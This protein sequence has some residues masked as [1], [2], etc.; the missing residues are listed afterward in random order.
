MALILWALLLPALA[1]GQ[2]PPNPPSRPVIRAVQVVGVI[3]PVKA[4][5]VTRELAAA[6]TAG[7]AAFLIEL[8]TPGGLDS[9]M[10]EII[11]AILGSRVPV[12]VY[13]SPPG[14]RA[15]SAGALITLAADFAAMAPGTNI[16]AAHPVSIGPGEGGGKV[17]AEKVLHDAVAYARSI[18]EARGR[19]PGWAEKMVRESVS[20][21]ASEALKHKVI[22]L[23]APDR[24]TLLK[25]LDGRPYRRN[26]RT[27]AL[28]SA[29]AE[30]QSVEMGWSRHLLDAVGNPDV[31]YLLLMLGMLGIFFEIASP[32]A[33]LPGTV[34]AIALLLAFFGLQALPVNAIGALLI[35]VAFILFILEI[36]IA[37]HG[38]LTVAGLTALAF[39]SLMLIESPAPFLRISRTVIA[40]VL[41][42]TAGFIVFVLALV[43]RA[44]RSPF[45]AGREAMAGERGEA[46]TG[47]HERGRV[48]VHGEYWHAFSKE[49]IAKGEAVEVVRMAEGLKL[50]VKR[51]EK[52]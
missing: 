15:A 51:P 44:Q 23:I 43:A 42:V 47:V 16:G 46:V 20:I 13:V 2:A 48:F 22:D 39:G 17:M 26:G 34:G 21:P 50:E 33:V 38:M 19:D 37:S 52:T 18:A 5:F 36:G 27:L 31:A 12:I 7:N 29:G 41:A 45:R 28:R 6:N 49:P 25:E 24:T 3:N 4:G 9:S 30:V 8:D 10:R 35:A 32:G 1:L 14:A 11:Q 40:A